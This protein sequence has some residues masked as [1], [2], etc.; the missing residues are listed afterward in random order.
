MLLLTCNLCLAQQKNRMHIKYPPQQLSEDAKVFR[1][2]VLAMHPV[3]G[4]YESRSKYEDDFAKLIGSLN[5]SLTEKEFRLRLKLLMD[6]LHCGHSDVYYSKETMA[7][8]GKQR[9]NFSPYLFLPVGEKVYLLGAMLDKPD[10]SFHKG[11]EIV[12]I[13][14]IGVDSMIRYMRRLITTDGYSPIAKDHYIQLGFNTYF[15]AL[16][17]RPDTF[18]VDFLDGYIKKTIRFPAK[19]YRNLPQL[20]LKQKQDSLFHRIRRSGVS[21]RYLDNNKKTIVVRIDAFSHSAYARAHRRIF[22]RA[23]RHGVDKMIIDLRNNGGGSLANTY[24]LLSYVMDHPVNQTL[25][26]RVRNY[27]LKQ[28][29]KGNVWFRLTR[30]IFSHI[31]KHIVV[32]DTDVYVYTIVPRKRNHY[33]GALY[34][35]TNGGTFSAAAMTAAYIKQRPNS[36][37][38]GEETGGAAEGCNAGVTAVYRLPNTGLRVF[39]PAFRIVHDVSSNK[40]GKGVLPNVPIHYGYK[41][42]QLRRDLELE[43]FLQFI[44]K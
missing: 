9:L 33:D 34:V 7:I 24:N 13:N 30:F 2:A 11:C 28:Y 42:L 10:S 3:I 27:P 43:Y 21:W 37:L 38:I 5:D 40:T 8:I 17:G 32:G 1:D 4:F 41:D 36:M 39:V 14:G 23:R 31:G 25:K 12:S 19:Q 26:T 29:T 22:R 15:P 44:Q 16:F 20:P 35:F 6:Q 18:T